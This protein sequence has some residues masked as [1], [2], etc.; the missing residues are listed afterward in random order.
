M[1]AH[2][3]GII[4]VLMYYRDLILLINTCACELSSRPKILNTAS[5]MNNSEI[6]AY[7]MPLHGSPT[8][9]LSWPAFLFYLSK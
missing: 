1:S 2:M 9:A 7:V 4:Y 8:M 5:L 3:Y 6:L